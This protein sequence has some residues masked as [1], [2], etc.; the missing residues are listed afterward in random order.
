MGSPCPADIPAGIMK[1][2]RLHAGGIAADVSSVSCSREFGGIRSKNLNRVCRGHVAAVYRVGTQ[3]VIA[4]QHG[5]QAGAP[6]VVARRE[7]CT[8]RVHC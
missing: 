2:I 1:I 7:Q 4:P 8:R 5:H 6:T 3:L